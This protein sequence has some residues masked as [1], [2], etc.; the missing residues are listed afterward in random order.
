MNEIW[1]EIVESFLKESLAEKI[2][3]IYFFL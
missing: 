3:F 2:A 1:N